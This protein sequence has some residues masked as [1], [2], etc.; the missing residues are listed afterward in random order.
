MTVD[1]EEAP[2]SGEESLEV[3]TECEALLAGFEEDL[4]GRDARVAWSGRDSVS[5]SSAQFLGEEIE[6]GAVLATASLAGVTAPDAG[7][8]EAVGVAM[9]FAAC[10]YE[11]VDAMATVVYAS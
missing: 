6:A 9:P 3:S 8:L 10:A 1:D 11:N 2:R 7:L 5:A 4:S